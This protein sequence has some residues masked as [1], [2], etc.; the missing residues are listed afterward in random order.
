LVWNTSA[1]FSLAE[2]SRKIVSSIICPSY[3]DVGVKRGSGLFPNPAQQWSLS[4]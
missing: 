4:G 3:N 1:R 2:G